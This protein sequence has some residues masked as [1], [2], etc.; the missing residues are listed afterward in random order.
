MLAGWLTALACVLTACGGGAASSQGQATTT[1]AP[2]G[3]AP[4]TTGSTAPSATTATG[5]Q[6]GGLPFGPT[7]LPSELFGKPFTGTKLTLDPNSA[8]DTLTEVRGSGMRVFMILVGS[9]RHYKNQDGTFNLEMWKARVDRFRDIDISEFIA[10][11][12]IIGHQLVEEAK[13]RA[14]WGGAVI[15]N[16]VLDEMAHYSKQIWPTMATVHRVDPSHLSEHA[17]GYQTAWPEWQWT[18]LD[19]AWAQYLV[20]KGPV[21]EYAAAQQA[22]ANRQNLALVVGLNVLNGGDGSSGI[23]SPDVTGKWAMSP[24]EVRRYGSTLLTRAAGCAFMMWRYETPGSGFEDFEYFRRPDI[25]AAMVELA[26]L[27][28]QQPARSCGRDE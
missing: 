24:D 21:E 14:Q 4:T 7:K 11:G 8:V 13:A 3:A 26:T 27:A 12:T 16:D 2:N 1:I 9:Q 28:A 25:E 20:R 5:R 10:D 6:A 19:T 18:Y 17:A 23:P 22:E 15:P